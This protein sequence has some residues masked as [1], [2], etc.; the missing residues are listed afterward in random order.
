MTTV[1]ELIDKLKEFD[2]D[3][4][5]FVDGYEFGVQE[6]DIENIKLEK[7]LL[8]YHKGCTYGGEHSVSYDRNDSED[9]ETIQGIVISR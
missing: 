7:I 1:K 3:F 8:N 5:I 9:Y 4:K 2:P 6:L